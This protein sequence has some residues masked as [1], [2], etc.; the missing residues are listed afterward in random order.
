MR[1]VNIKLRLNKEEFKEVKKLAKSFHYFQIRNGKKE[2]NVSAY[3][4]DAVLQKAANRI[5]V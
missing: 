1:D 3:T 2:I 4:R 5:S